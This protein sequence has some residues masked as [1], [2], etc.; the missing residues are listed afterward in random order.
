[1][2]LRTYAYSDNLQIGLWLACCWLALTRTESSSLC[3]YQEKKCQ[4]ILPESYSILVNQSCLL[5]FNALNEIVIAYL[6]DLLKRYSS[7]PGFHSAGAGKLLV[8][9]KYFVL[10][11]TTLATHYNIIDDIL[12][13]KINQLF[14]LPYSHLYQF[15]FLYVV[16]VQ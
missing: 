15:L 11:Y 13:I 14:T 1:M 10:H 5:Q 4:R 8:C 6:A 7:L 9:E 2:M 3:P 16:I 12:F